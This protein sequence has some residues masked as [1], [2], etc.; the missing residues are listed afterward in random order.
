MDLDTAIDAFLQHLS[1]ERGLS[2]NTIECYGRDLASFRATAG[3]RSLS[4]V[5]APVVRRHLERLQS[6]GLAPRSR[7]R[8]LSALSQWFRYLRAEGAL[9][10]D[11]LEGI[12]RPRVR[13]RTPEVLSAREVD[14]LLRSPD[15]SPLGIRDRAM[16][17]TLYAGGLRVSELVGLDGSALELDS[18]LCWVEGKGRRQRI[19]PLGEACIAALERYLREVRPR[20]DR[21]RSEA[22]VFLSARGARITR[23]AVWYRVRYHA[24]LAGIRARLSPHGLRHSFATHLLEGGA[25]LRSV[26]ELL[27]HADIGTTEIYTH[28]SRERLRSLIDRAHPRGGSV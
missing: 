5:D 6:E 25:D 23:Q 16:L 4:S 3:E 2:A 19:A 24:R 14:A 11:P 27:G 17:E 20:W 18:A 15:E 8:A 1:V 7:G 21:S 12:A 10:G 9:A 22:A 28:V 26:Q 13:R